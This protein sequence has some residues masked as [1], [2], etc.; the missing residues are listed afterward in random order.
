M[1]KRLIALIAVGLVTLVGC[2]TTAAPDRAPVPDQAAPVAAPATPA[3]TPAYTVD[4][5]PSHL[6]IPS[7]GAESSFVPVGTN[8]DGSLAVP[9]VHT[10][11]Q[12][13]WFE[14]GPEPGQNGPAV[15]V[16]HID[17]D[18]IE[19][20]FWKLKDVKDGDAVNVTRADGKALHFVVYR[21]ELVAKDAFPASDVFG[22]AADPELRLITC[23][24]S[25]DAAAHSY[26]GNTI[27]FAKLV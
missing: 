9:S 3:V 19:G 21:T 2:G 7:I 18:H 26:R 6:S 25:F 22:Y 27:V 12:A 4:V 23:G 10:P 5:P 13:A 1:S 17:G 24:G 20:V 14:P 8:A 15:I 11:K 16:G